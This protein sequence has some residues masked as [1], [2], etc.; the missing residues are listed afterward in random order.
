[1][2]FALLRLSSGRKCA[3]LRST[4]AGESSIPPR[5]QILVRKPKNK[6]ETLRCAIAGQADVERVLNVVGCGGGLLYDGQQYVSRWEDLKYGQTYTAVPCFTNSVSDVTV[7]HT[8]PDED[9]ETIYPFRTI[10]A[11]VTP[12]QSANAT[13]C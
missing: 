11:P 7:R 3:A 6:D 13:G 12:R 5:K 8:P 10:D 4:A 9:K 1:M 2:R